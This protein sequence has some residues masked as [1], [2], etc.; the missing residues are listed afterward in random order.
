M[1]RKLMDMYFIPWSAVLRTVNCDFQNRKSNLSIEFVL[2]QDDNYYI[3][4]T[5]ETYLGE[6]GSQIGIIGKWES[7]GID[8]DDV[9]SRE[10]AE[11]YLDVQ[12]LEDYI[13]LSPDYFSNY[14]NKVRYT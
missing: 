11:G 2:P 8:F 9:I 14:Y 13:E 6:E 7:S 5:G 4:R 10:F 12:H 1:I 3:L